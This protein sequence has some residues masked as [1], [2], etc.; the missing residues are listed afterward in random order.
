LRLFFFLLP[1]V[2]A[3]VQKK[4]QNN[5]SISPRSIGPGDSRTT[6]NAVLLAPDFPLA[7]APRGADAMWTTLFSVAFVIAISLNLVALSLSD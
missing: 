1:I 6:Y 5:N 4:S 2:P 3:Q 7:L